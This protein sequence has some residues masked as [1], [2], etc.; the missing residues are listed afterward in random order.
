MNR[1]RFRIQIITVRYG[2][3]FQ[4]IIAGIKDRKNRIRCNRTTT[5]CICFLSLRIIFGIFF[6]YFRVIFVFFGITFFGIIVSDT[7]AI[8]FH[9]R[10][11]CH[12]QS[13]CCLY[14]SICCRIGLIHQRKSHAAFCCAVLRCDKGG[15]F[16]SCIHNLHAIHVVN[17]ICCI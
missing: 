2:N 11:F 5:D 10:I 4:I 17:I 16:G 7:I 13:R 1:N 6:I 14:C 8:R 3:F 15:Q 12:Y 9:F